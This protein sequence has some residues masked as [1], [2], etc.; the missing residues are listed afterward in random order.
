MDYSM[1]PEQNTYAEFA[2]ALRSLPSKI[3]EIQLEILSKTEEQ[4]SLEKEISKLEAKIKSEINIA[5]D[6]NGKKVF[7]NTEMRAAELFERLEADLE[8]SAIKQT[9]E[10]L[11]KN[12]STIKIELEYV[13]NKQRNARILVDLFSNASK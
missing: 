2:E 4:S 5:T 8:I 6:A 3:K 11:S 13:N 10:K 1:R 9:H 12:I 7:T